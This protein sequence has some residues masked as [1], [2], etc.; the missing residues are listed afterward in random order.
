MTSYIA[1]RLFYAIFTFLGI[2]VVTF[3]LIHAVPG[4][5]IDFLASKGMNNVKSPA[6][7]AALRHEFHLD[8]PLVV[9]YLYWFRGIVTLDFGRSSVDRRRVVERI[10]EKLPRT[11]VLNSM[12][13]LLA[14][15]IGL[16]VGLWSATRSG[17]LLE[18]GSSVL[19]FLL[20]SLPT[21][22]VAL[23]LMEWFAVRLS[24]L[25]LF[26][27]TSDDFTT[28][29]TAQQ[30]ADRSRHFV[31]PV[32]TLCYGQIAILARFTKSSLTEVIRQDFITTARAKGA[33]E[34]A[35]LLVHAFRN[36]LIPLVTLLG[37]IVPSLISGSVIV[38]TMFQWDGVGRLYYD[39]IFARDYP[40]VLA[41]TVGT[42]VVTLLASLAADILYAIADP[43]IRVGARVR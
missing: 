26:G 10:L 27:M 37:L 30:F 16:P 11:F 13:F 39:A 14:A 21:F 1:R 32:I 6:Q 24:A 23:L 33:G 29:T 31:L 3:S 43:R 35:V 41:L 8:Q 34:G 4:D 36:A 19:F 5:P 28:M 20:Y 42:A 2:T 15:L 7:V 17:H 9:Q 40:T 22:W 25:P 38:E 18:R 12:A